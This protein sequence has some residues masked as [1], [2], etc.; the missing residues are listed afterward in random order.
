MNIL[1]SESNSENLPREI[2]ADDSTVQLLLPHDSKYGA[3]VERN[4]ASWKLGWNVDLLA[5]VYCGVVVTGISY[6]LLVWV[7]EKRGPVFPAMF[8]PLPLIMTAIFSAIFLHETLH[9]G[10]SVGRSVV[11]C[12]WVGFMLSF[13]VSTERPNRNWMGPKRKPIWN[14]S[15]RRSRTHPIMCRRKRLTRGNYHHNNDRGHIFILGY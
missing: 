1:F 14:P 5:I 12:W 13:G 7:I 3:I 4:I 6:S 11:Y 8:S 2:A 15:L 10:R 9:W